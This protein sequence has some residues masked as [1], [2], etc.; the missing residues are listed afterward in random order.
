MIHRPFRIPEIFREL[1]AVHLEPK[2]LRF[3]HPYADAEPTMVL[4]EAVRGGKPYLHAEPPLVIY[5]RDRTYTEELLRI[6]G[7]EKAEA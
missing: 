2:R 4:V 6:Y 3:V 7:L 1:T 5:N